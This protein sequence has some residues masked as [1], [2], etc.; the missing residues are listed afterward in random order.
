MQAASIRLP[1]EKISSANPRSLNTS[2]A[3]IPSVMPDPTR[4]NLEACSNTCFLPWH[5]E[6]KKR[7]IQLVG[8]P[9]A[10]NVAFA[11]AG[12]AADI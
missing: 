9:V 12:V 1:L 4:R 3:L 8:T 11:K 2:M 5:R 10:W 6:P 7:F